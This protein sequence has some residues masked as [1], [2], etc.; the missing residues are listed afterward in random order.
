[1]SNF[2][3]IEV[4]QPGG[5]GA[6]SPLV[7]PSTI[8]AFVLVNLQ[9]YAGGRNIWGES[10]SRKKKWSKPSVADGLIE[11]SRKHKVC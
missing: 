4:Q 1:M 3:S 9:S 2:S 11:V 8:K 10:E 5:D 6:W 7:I